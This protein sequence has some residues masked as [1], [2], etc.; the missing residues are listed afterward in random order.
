VTAQHDEDHRWRDPH[1]GEPAGSGRTAGRAFARGAG[2]TARGVGATA[3]GVGRFGRYAFGQARRAADAQGA[4]DSGLN[5]LIEMHAFNTAGDA[6]VAI[7][8]AGSLF[9]QVPSGDGSSSRESVALFLGLTM[10]P[11]AIVAPLIGPF[12]DRF[13]HGR[14]WAIGATMAVR[15]FLCWVLAGALPEQSPVMFPAALGVLVA[16]KAYGVTRAAAVPRLL[17]RDFTLVKGNGRVSMAGIV[18]VT[19]A[20]PIAGLASLAGPEWDLRWAF[21]LFVI[22]T[23]GAI[24]LP[25]KVDSSAGEGTIGFREGE[26]AG[27][28]LRMRMPASVAYALRANCAPKWLYGFLLM[29]MAFLLQEHP[30]HGW[31]ST[32][33]LA[34]V[35]GGA[36]VGNFLGVVAASL[37]RRIRPAVAVSVVMVADALVALLAALFY[38]VPMLAVLGLVAGLGQA[39]AKFSLDSSIQAHIPTAVQASAFARSDT[40]LQLAWVIGGFVGIA[41]PLHARFGLGVACAVLT[42]WAAYVLVTRPRRDRTVSA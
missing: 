38:S 10:L 36:G 6:A 8:L 33:L 16:S 14:R 3:R 20:A 18:G 31:S 22:A 21:V 13:S 11:F 28:G 2:A 32:V 19:V 15:A 41:L 9:F 35:A 1:E 5:R 42:A 24:R 34:I 30:L 17:P 7:S 25:A 27:G 37:V 39:L 26:T 23:I 12:L 40:T 4:A 29:F